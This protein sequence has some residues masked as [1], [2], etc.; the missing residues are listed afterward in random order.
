MNFIAKSTYILMK[1]MSIYLLLKYD[2]WAT[3]IGVVIVLIF[4][5]IF[6]RALKNEVG[7]TLSEILKKMLDYGCFVVDVC[8]LLFVIMLLLSVTHSSEKYLPYFLILAAEI[9]SFVIKDNKKKSKSL[10]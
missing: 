10:S 2:L 9:S 4:S 3:Y 8:F 5:S 7:H 6:M 1:I